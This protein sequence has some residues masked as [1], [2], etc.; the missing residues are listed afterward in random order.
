LIVAQ[1][2]YKYIARIDTEFA[3]IPEV[4]CSIGELNQVFLNLIVNATHAIQ[5]SGQDAAT[6]RIGIATAMQ[7]DWV[8]ITFADNGCGIPQQN[9]EKIFDPFFT[10]KEVG[11][12][13]GQGLS[14]SR[15]IVCE[16]H[17]GR[18]DVRSQV[19]AGTQFIIALPI[20]GRDEARAR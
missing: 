12:G 16:R 10:T 19:G 13:T 4:T 8:L 14:I 6:G 20:T 3:A 9:I 15:S 18:I 17:G 11:R 1:N 2:E 5:E 7:G